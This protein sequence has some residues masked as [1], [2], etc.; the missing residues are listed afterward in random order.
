[1]GVGVLL[2]F[3][4][5]DRIAQQRPGPAGRFLLRN[6]LGAFLEPQGL[7]REEYLV[8]PE[9]DGR[10]PES[11]IFVAAP[12]ALDEIRQWFAGDIVAEDVVDWD[13]ATRSVS[14]RRRER[15]G[16]I[17]LREAPLRNPDPALVWAAMMDRVRKAGTGALPWD[18]GA[19]RLRE[20]ITFIRTLDP[21]WPD[22]TDG[23]LMA[24]LEE[25]LGPRL[26]G[27]TRWDDLGRVVL[28]GA[29]L[30]LVGWERRVQLDRLAPTHVVVPSGSR[31][32]VDYGDPERPVLAVRLQ[33]M[34]GLTETPRVGQGAVPL[35]LHLLSPAGRPVQV[36]RDLA[37][38][39]RTS[40]FD[41]RKDLKGRYPRHH[42]PD[43]PLRAEPT[44][45][46][47]PKK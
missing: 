17:V 6:G 15:L 10:R 42:W 39:W 16:A 34:F 9:L 20:R 36:T 12:L 5:P 8:I 32:P 25:W 11:R 44:K 47:R 4:Y 7:S 28:G 26:V 30:D 1:V 18:D 38:F 41:V 21:G 46:V 3:A 37:G 35:T 29:L 43:D 14:G 19:S 22:V 24:S 13:P 33:E 23:A 40:Y 31:V 2:A 27:L 45:R